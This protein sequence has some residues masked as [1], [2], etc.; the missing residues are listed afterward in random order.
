MTALQPPDQAC[1]MPGC[2]TCQFLPLKQ[3][4]FGPT[5][6][7]KMISHRATMYTTA[8]DGDLGMFR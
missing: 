4:D 2:S 6:F 5:F 3:N 8:D 7:G 1:C